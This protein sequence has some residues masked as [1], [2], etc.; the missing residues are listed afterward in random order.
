MRADG[1]GATPPPLAQ[2]ESHFIEVGPSDT[3]S[4][5]KALTPFI[6]SLFFGN[7]PNERRVVVVVVNWL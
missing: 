1:P 5:H 3:D 2:A 7:I 4:T 6:S